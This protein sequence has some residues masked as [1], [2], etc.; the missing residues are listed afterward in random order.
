MVLGKR[1]GSLKNSSRGFVLLTMVVLARRTATECLFVNKNSVAVGKK[2]ESSRVIKK[3]GADAMS[4]I[5]TSGTKHDPGD[6]KT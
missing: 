1:Q 3:V 5:F 2:I 6:M 4:N